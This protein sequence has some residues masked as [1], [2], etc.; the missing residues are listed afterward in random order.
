[1]YL[2]L[3]PKGQRER[4]SVLSSEAATPRPKCEVDTISTENTT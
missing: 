3:T 4:H 1:M 2:T